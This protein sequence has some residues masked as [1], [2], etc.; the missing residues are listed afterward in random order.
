MNVVNAISME[1]LSFFKPH[2]CPCC[3]PVALYLS[4][5]VFSAPAGWTKALLPRHVTDVLATDMARAM[6]ASVSNTGLAVL[7]QAA[8][9]VAL[10]GILFKAMGKSASTAAKGAAAGCTAGA[11][12]AA[13]LSDEEPV[14]LA[15][16]GLAY[17]VVGVVS[18]LVLQVPALREAL[19]SVAAAAV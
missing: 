14:A 8:M 3:D 16:G 1:L 7:L 2:I 12:G 5:G 19:V 11:I 4:C 17:A 18:C 15:N 6:N 9:T 10:G 13:G